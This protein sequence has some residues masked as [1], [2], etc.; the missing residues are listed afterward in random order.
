MDGDG[1]SYRLLLAGT[2][3]FCSDSLWKRKSRNG[4]YLILG[5]PKLMHA[6]G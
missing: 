1:G 3:G 2:F 6:L 4:R 5:A